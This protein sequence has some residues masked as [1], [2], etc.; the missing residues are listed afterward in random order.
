MGEQFVEPSGQGNFNM[1][2]DLAEGESEEI[3]PDLYKDE[4]DKFKKLHP[5]LKARLVKQHFE[6]RAKQNEVNRQKDQHKGIIEYPTEE[7]CNIFVRDNIKMFH[8]LHPN[9]YTVYYR[10]NP[11]SKQTAIIT[12]VEGRESENVMPRRGRSY[13]IRKDVEGNLS[14]VK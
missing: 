3:I 12:I 6:N 1:D 9:E 13:Y 2:D 8:L 11:E 5:D 14:L 4:P 7:E 10:Q